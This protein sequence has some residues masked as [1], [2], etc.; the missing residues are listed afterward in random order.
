MPKRT[1]VRRIIAVRMTTEDHD[2][3][4]AAAKQAGKSV[5]KFCVALIQAAT[6]K[7]ERTEA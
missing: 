7:P 6:T 2:A 1:N 3:L 4:K 5:N